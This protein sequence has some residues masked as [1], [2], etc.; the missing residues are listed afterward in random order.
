MGEEGGAVVLEVPLA[1]SGAVPEDVSVAA[2]APVE[3]AVAIDLCVAD[4]AAGLA[5]SL[6]C[7]PQKFC[8]CEC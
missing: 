4:S 8:D 1:V 3:L 6:L 2:V 5:S 7:I